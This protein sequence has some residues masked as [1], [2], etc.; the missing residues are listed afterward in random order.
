MLVV[1]GEPVTR[2]ALCDVLAAFGVPVVSAASGADAVLVARQHRRAV[3][4]LDVSLSPA[5]EAAALAGG[6]C[7][8]C[9]AALPIIATATDEGLAA[10]ARTIC[11]FAAL[12]K[13][14]ALDDL[15]ATVRSALALSAAAA[16]LPCDPASQPDVKGE[17]TTFP[18]APPAPGGST[19]RPS[20][21]Q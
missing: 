20:R 18:T 4:I 1:D 19:R 14:Y 6:L 13:P 21:P 8:A 16:Q 12:A 3:V 2:T 15:L 17:P 7:A 9:G 5:S 10:T 11:A